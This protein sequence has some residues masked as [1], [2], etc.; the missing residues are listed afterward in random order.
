MM[1]SPLLQHTL[2]KSSIYK[3]CVKLSFDAGNIIASIFKNKLNIDSLQKLSHP[4]FETSYCKFF[5][6]K[7][8]FDNIVELSALSFNNKCSLCIFDI[9]C[10]IHAKANGHCSD[11]ITDFSNFLAK[12]SKA[13]AFGSRYFL[14]CRNTL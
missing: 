4:S 2:I 3:S 14:T 9:T 6:R 10:N 5:E 1:V 12:S 13:S 8:R 11:I 7:N